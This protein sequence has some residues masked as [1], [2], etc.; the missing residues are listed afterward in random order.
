LIDRMPTSKEQ[1]PI[2]TAV[3][4]PACGG[5]A[6]RGKAIGYTCDGCKRQ[7]YMR[8]GKLYELKHDKGE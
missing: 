7:F 3:L 5:N 8:H 6:W 2:V 1:P 4:C